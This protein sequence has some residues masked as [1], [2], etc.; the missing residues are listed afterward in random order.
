MLDISQRKFLRR[1][2]VPHVLAHAVLDFHPRSA[3]SHSHTGAVDFFGIFLNI[4][5]NQLSLNIAQ[6]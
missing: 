3:G 1:S 4:N 2:H 6:M 5:F